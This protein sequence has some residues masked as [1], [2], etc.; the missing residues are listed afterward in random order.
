MKARLLRTILTAGVAI[1]LATLVSQRLS[2]QTCAPFPA[3]VVPF[4]MVHYIS[5]ANIYGDRFVVGELGGRLKKDQIPLPAFYNQRF[6]G[7]VELA[8][9]LL[10]EAYVPSASER[11]GYVPFV[12]S[13]PFVAFS[14]PSWWFDT[15]Y[16]E[17]DWDTFP[18]NLIPP[19]QIVDQEDG[20]V[21]GFHVWR[22]PPSNFISTLSVPILL[23]LA[24]ANDS[25]YTSELTLTN[26]S[27]K[28]VP[29]EFNYTAAYGEGSGKVT[30]ML[31]ARR[32]RI[33]PDAV[34]YLRS[35]GLAIPTSVNV[36]GTL[37]VKASGLVSPHDVAVSVRTTTALPEGRAGLAYSGNSTWKTFNG[38]RTLLEGLDSPYICGLRQNASD[39]SHVA[40][41]HAGKPDDGPIVLRLIVASGV[42]PFFERTLPDV[43]L[44][45]GGFHQVNEVLISN[46]LSLSNGYVRVERVSG[47]APFYAY[48]LINDQVNSD[49]SFVPPMV[50]TGGGSPETRL[51][52]PVMVETSGYASELVL[53][54]TSKRQQKLDFSFV[55]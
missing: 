28:D 26:R 11:A 51:T 23:S 36:G 55:A 46:G 45:P 16:G 27:A 50:P 25:Y 52:V 54:N 30:D 3:G 18:G 5:E 2:A 43:T 49:G 24:G 19:V 12:P 17:F 10:M 8:P 40:V 6:C 13:T 21:Y 35:L 53:I 32:Q 7:P 33:E 34:A 1:S 39:R 20:A 4:A 31:P 47:K 15:R 42:A 41:M 9:G 14:P 38:V 37:A 48:G 44:S 22:I 29:L